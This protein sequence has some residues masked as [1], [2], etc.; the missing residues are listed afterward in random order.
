MKMVLSKGKG[1]LMDRVKKVR[2]III[3]KDFIVIL[4]REIDFGAIVLCFTLSYSKCKGF[5][6]MHNFNKLF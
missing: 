5:P 2:I 1:G 3:K 6:F 4:K